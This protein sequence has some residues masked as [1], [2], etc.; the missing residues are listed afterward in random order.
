MQRNFKEILESEEWLNYPEQRDKA[1]L[2]YSKIEDKENEIKVIKEQL[3][4][5][6]KIVNYNKEIKKYRKE[7]NNL[8]TG[9]IGTQNMYEN[10]INTI[11]QQIEDLHSDVIPLEDECETLKDE[12][13]DIIKLSIGY[14]ISTTI[15][16]EPSSDVSHEFVTHKQKFKKINS[17]EINNKKNKQ[18]MYYRQAELKSKNKIQIQS[19]T[20]DNLKKEKDMYEQNIQ[21]IGEKLVTISRKNYS[22]RDEKKKIERERTKLREQCEEM[23]R[24]RDEVDI[25]I[26]NE[27]NRLYLISRKRG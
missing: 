24:K 4:Y 14:N 17:K 5:D 18:E 22:N 19:V 23:K 3:N 2:I 7:I 1:N 27:N 26:Y 15:N 12:F 11:L 16:L 25:K 21:S 9:D 20:L 13:E 6:E 8:S 10:K